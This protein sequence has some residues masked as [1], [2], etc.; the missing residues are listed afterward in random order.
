MDGTDNPLTHRDR[1][2]L[3]AVG[4]G[5]AEITV[6]A[7]PDLFLDGRCCADQVAAHRLA[8]AGLITSS[9]G[10]TIGQRVAARLSAAGRLAAAPDPAPAQPRAVV[11]QPTRLAA[12]A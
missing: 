2:I 6:G 12:I 10:G 11:V 7:E 1:A 5:P 4:R 9:G 8:R 3:R